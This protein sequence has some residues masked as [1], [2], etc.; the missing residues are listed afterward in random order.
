MLHFTTHH[1]YRLPQHYNKQICGPSCSCKDRFLWVSPIFEHY[2][3]LNYMGTVCHW[4]PFWSRKSFRFIGQCWNFNP[5]WTPE[6]GIIRASC[7][8]TIVVSREK[9]AV[10]KCLQIY[11]CLWRGLGGGGGTFWLLN[12]SLTFKGPAA[13]QATAF[14]QTGVNKIPPNF[15]TLFATSLEV[16]RR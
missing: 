1:P 10:T 7:V 6:Q 5:Q 8:R 12:E 13:K 11:W 3:C 2:I 9:C 15:D 4:Q 16:V 14:N